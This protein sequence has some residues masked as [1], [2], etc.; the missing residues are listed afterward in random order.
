[1][2]GL[3]QRDKSSG[4]SR[5]AERPE[6]DEKVLRERSITT[7]KRQKFIECLSNSDINISTHT[8][9]CKHSNFWFLWC[10]RAAKDLLGWYPKR[11]S[12][13]GMAASP[14]THIFLTIY[15]PQLKLPSG[16]S[17]F[18]DKSA[19]KYTCKEE[20]WISKHGRPSFC[21][22][23]WRFRSTNMAPNWNRRSKNT[24]RCQAVDAC[25]NS[26]SRITCR[27]QHTESV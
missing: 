11:S 19:I 16:I 12:S 17:S 22:G 20:V 21:Q 14:G 24:T 10:R 7:N 6:K 4:A 3:K 18:A 25:W 8:A 27:I 23:S 1:M 13:H 9:L 15:H 5:S 2:N 26:K